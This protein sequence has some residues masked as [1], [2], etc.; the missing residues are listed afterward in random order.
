[1]PRSPR[2]SL[3]SPRAVAGLVL[4]LLVSPGCA[5]AGG[6]GGERAGGGAGLPVFP[7]AATLE[8]LAQQPAP[9][10]K[11]DDARPVQR[12]E[13][14]GPLP[15]VLGTTPHET[16]SA[17]ARLA[18][19][20]LG[21]TPRIRLSAGMQC[22]AREYGRFQLA[23]GAGPAPD[24]ETFLQAR[25][26]EPMSHARVLMR[27]GAEPGAVELGGPWGA[28]AKGLV[29]SLPSG[30]DMTAGIWSGE[31]D[32]RSIMVLA[33]AE[34]FVELEPVAMDAGSE[35]VIELRGRFLVQAGTAEAFITRGKYGYETCEPDPKIA[36]P[37]FRFRCPAAPGEESAII[38]MM[39]SRPRRVLG[40]RA[41][42]GLV[43]PGRSAPAEFTS[44]AL[45]A[46][47]R[48]IVEQERQ[49]LVAAI[50]RLRANHGIG[51]L[52]VMEAQSAVT[53]RVLPQ[54]FAAARGG[55]AEVAD[56][57]ALGLLAGWE[58]GGGMVRDADFA[59][60]NFH[61][62][63]TME[64]GLETLLMTPAMRTML[65]NPKAS[66][67][68]LASRAYDEGRVISAL[69]TTYR[70]FGTV[71]YV[72]SEEALL[73]RLDR[74]RAAVG[75]PPVIRVGGNS[76]QPLAAARESIKGGRDAGIALNS[77]LRRLVDEVGIDMRGL[78]LY[79]SD[80]NAISFPPDLITAPR[81]QI[82]LDIDHFQPRGSPWGTFFIVV[83]YT[84]N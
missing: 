42:L 36:L 80:L 65:L 40:E 17:V 34:R 45:A 21:G 10:A 49:S 29:A 6:G 79:T 31:V 57:I 48:P 39:F 76:A 11:G 55:A 73:D 63:A 9:D 81:V 64:Q 13:M 83:V 30:K 37:A 22:L 28:A 66:S 58:V 60:M 15:T 68:A 2:S 41:M 67:I 43:T 8:A 23:H 27:T 38:E 54:F 24:L 53:G 1:M 25:C 3:D 7:S 75:K 51:E 20:V 59:A 18:A 78:V 71:D 61:G 56:T 14:T 47:D 50:N 82:D 84:T 69:V 72:A 4:A 46:N 77:A 26:G 33:F 5:S 32:G 12:W 70:Y 52:V 44:R 19:E 74:W 62:V 35:G 16:E